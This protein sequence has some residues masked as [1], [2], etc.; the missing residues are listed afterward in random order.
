P[1]GCAAYNIDATQAAQAGSGY[2]SSGIAG[3]Y[4]KPWSQVFV[5]LTGYIGK[6]VQVNL[7]TTDCDGGAHR[8][9]AYFDFHCSPFFF[10]LNPNAGCTGNSAQIIAPGGAATYNWTTLG[11]GTIISGANTQTI[12]VNTSGDYQVTMTA[13]GSGCSYTIDTTITITAVPVPTASFSAVPVCAGSPMQFT[14]Q[15]VTNGAPPFTSWSWNFGNGNTSTAQNPTN[16]YNTSGTF[17][18]TFTANNGCPYTYSTTVTVNPSPTVTVTNATIC[19]G[20]TPVA[21]TA[22]G[23]N[24][25]TWNTGVTGSN[26]TVSPNA[27][28]SY[29]VTGSSALGCTVTATT[30]ITVNPNP[31]VTVNNATICDG[32]GPVTL[33]AAG[34]NTYTWSTGA[35]GNSI[36]ISPATTTNYT[37]AAST[38]A[39]CLGSATTSITVIP[40]PTVTAV[41]SLVC[42]GFPASLNANGAATYT[43]TGP[44][45]V[46][47]NGASVTANPPTTATY[48]VVGTTATC[49]AS[50]VAT[51]TVLPTPT[52]V[53]TNQGPFCPGDIVPTPTFTSNP[54][55]PNT[56]FVWTNSNTSIGLNGTGVAIP[57]SFT[58]NV[59]STLVNIQ[60]VITV[61]PTLNGCVGPPASYTIVLKPTPFVNYTPSVEYCPNVN[62]AAI[63]FTAIPGGGVPSFFWGY[64]PVPTSI[65]LATSGIGSVPSFSTINTGTT[66]VSGTIYVHAVLNGCTGPDSL[67]TITVNPSPKASFVYSSACIGKSTSLTDESTIGVGSITN[68]SWDL[69]ND[70]IFGDATNQNPTYTFAPAGSHNVGLTVTSNKGCKNIIY[71]PVYVNFLPAPNFAGDNLMGCPVHPV[72]FTESSVAVAP[73]HVISWS[74]DF[75]NG[76][77]SVSQSPTTVLFYNSSPL[78]PINYTVSLT[79]KTDSGCVGTITKPN[80]ITV[81]PQPI[82]GF[83][84]DPADADI[85]DPTI[86]FTNTSVGGSGNLPIKYYLG[87]VFIGQQDPRNWTNLT[88]PIH[89]YNDQTPDT[90]YVTQWVKNIYGCKDSITHPITINPAYT[91]YIPNAFSPNG[92]NRNDGFKGTGIGIDPTTY[93][94]WVF[95]R[96][97]NEIFHTTNMEE[98]WNGRVNEVVVQ[99]DTYVWKVRFSDISGAKHEY[100]GIVNLIK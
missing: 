6:N 45:L 53:V 97:G 86:H 15:S 66:V 76:Q 83:N 68:W 25:Y 30:S 4:Y 91:F 37:V 8:G 72:N 50:T 92:D 73:A 61:T 13:F 63:N 71:E 44:N 18:V 81:Y 51:V 46:S 96:W 99:E 14:D 64:N 77:T 20:A 29:T 43:W 58:C 2:L 90:Y 65:G 98:T 42:F 82:A 1:I 100:N 54:N 52:V 49:T 75:G 85:L 31:T 35:I 23:A 55:D 84:W 79:V 5:P 89:T 94:I 57:P 28:T 78:L 10:T 22:N 93:N 21:L 62:T 80:Y 60:S 16:V 95:D 59:N 48:T 87:D 70:G 11:S 41:G 33:T 27:T 47:N 39:G 3:L 32:A 12:T 67:F 9:Y 69:N 74:W 17:A 88:N 34:A 7:L 36:S 38:A 19:S 56:T 24:T 26:L 40:N